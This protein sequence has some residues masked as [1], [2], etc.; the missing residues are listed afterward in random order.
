MNKENREGC[1][2]ASVSPLFWEW[3]DAEQMEKDDVRG[4]VI[5]Q[6]ISSKKSVFSVILFEYMRGE[7]SRVLSSVEY[8]YERRPA[9]E[10]KEED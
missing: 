7:I 6:A 1:S 9:S 3:E 4:N 5:L 10:D 2:S 8:S